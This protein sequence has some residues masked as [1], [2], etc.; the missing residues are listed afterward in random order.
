[1]PHT[2]TEEL[3]LIAESSGTAR[4]VPVSTVI[5]DPLIKPVHIL[6]FLQPCF[7]N[8]YSYCVDDHSAVDVLL[9]YLPLTF[10]E[11][12]HPSPYRLFGTCNT[13]MDWNDSSSFSDSSEEKEDDV[14]ED[15]DNSLSNSS[16]SNR[17]NPL[18]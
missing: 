15:S 8:Q 10:R 18:F 13:D 9:R 16:G 11:A 2:E 6:D 14:P 12:A 7:R 1:M 4:P 17:S 3:S 5:M